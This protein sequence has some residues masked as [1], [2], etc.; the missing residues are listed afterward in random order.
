MNTDELKRQTR[1]DL[2]VFV[3]QVGRDL[4]TLKIKAH[5]RAMSWRQLEPLKK[6]SGASCIHAKICGVLGD[7]NS[8]RS[9]GWRAERVAC[10]SVSTRWAD[11][12]TRLS[13]VFAGNKR[14]IKSR[15][16]SARRHSF[17]CMNKQQIFIH[18]ISP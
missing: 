14:G 18:L 6:K 9:R 1:P 10:E 15:E 11:S 2:F 16:S 17:Y 7:V 13:A 5:S 8:P 3:H 12:L 4:D